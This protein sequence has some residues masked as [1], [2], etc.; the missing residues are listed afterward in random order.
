MLQDRGMGSCQELAHC[1]RRWF[2]LIV[3]VEELLERVDQLWRRLLIQR[4]EHC[5]G[6]VGVGIVVVAGHDIVVGLGHGRVI[7]HG[8]LNGYVCVRHFAWRQKVWI[9]KKIGACCHHLATE[10][11]FLSG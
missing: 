10:T 4:R 2:R 6:I 1:V 5:Y 3:V 7:R 11:L 8:T 9:A